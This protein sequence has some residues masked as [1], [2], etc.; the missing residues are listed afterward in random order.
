M[1]T[2]FHAIMASLSLLWTFGFLSCR[3]LGS[4][5]CELYNRGVGCQL[6]FQEGH[7]VNL[8]CWGNDCQDSSFPSAPLRVKSLQTIE[9]AP[10]GRHGLLSLLGLFHPRFSTFRQT[11][12]LNSKGDI[13]FLFPRSFHFMSYVSSQGYIIFVFFCR[14]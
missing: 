5:G 14:I 11:F 10:Q 8:P 13:S 3:H 2:V 1:A 12:L 7:V 4:M 9:V 6:E